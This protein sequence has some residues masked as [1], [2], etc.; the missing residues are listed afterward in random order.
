MAGSHLV[1][2]VVS[3]F[4]ALPAEGQQFILFWYRYP[5][6]VGKAE[7]QRAWARLL[8]ADRTAALD[9]IMPQVAFWQ[10]SGTQRLFIPHAATWLNQ[11]RWE[12]ELEDLDAP[13][14][15][16][17]QCEWNRN[18]NREPGAGRCEARAKHASP[19]GTCYCPAHA[20]KAGLIR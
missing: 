14:T 2:N 19:H 12:D 6:K 5:R 15:D 16:L 13:L 18:G 1:G 9:R 20:R 11:R 17:G 7:A 4:G 10:L 8:P 3:L